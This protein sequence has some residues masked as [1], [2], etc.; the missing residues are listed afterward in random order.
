MT[1]H[2]HFMARVS[3]FDVIRKVFEIINNCDCFIYFQVWS[4][5]VAREC[6]VVLQSDTSASAARNFM[7][8]TRI[9]THLLGNKNILQELGL[10]S[11]HPHCDNLSFVSSSHSQRTP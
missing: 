8:A 11:F 6:L 3:V 1:E 2:S 4:G 5:L 10:Y 9:Q 7:L